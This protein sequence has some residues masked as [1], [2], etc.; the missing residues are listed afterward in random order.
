[1]GEPQTCP[2][3]FW[4]TQILGSGGPP[5]CLLGALPWHIQGNNPRQTQMSASGM[6]EHTHHLLWSLTAAPTGDPGVLSTDSTRSPLRNSWVSDYSTTDSRLADKGG[7]RQ[8]LWCLGTFSG[9]PLGPLLIKPA[10]QCSLAHP[11]CSQSQKKKTKNKQTRN[12]GLL[13]VSNR[14]LRS[15]S[16]QHLTLAYTSLRQYQSHIQREYPAGKN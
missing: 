10:L 9:P 11:G 7:C 5:T 3:S 2:P 8:I 1:M 4:Q 6:R 16:G 12:C 13:A 14:L 15:R